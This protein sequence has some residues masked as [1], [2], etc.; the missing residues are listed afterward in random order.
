VEHV[1]R[2][3][4]ERLRHLHVIIPIL[5]NSSL[6]PTF[7]NNELEEFISLLVIERM[8]APSELFHHSSLQDYL[9]YKKRSTVL[10]A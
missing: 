4:A 6:S 10:Y 2:S 7:H 1:E 8:D 3:I 9:G 5:I